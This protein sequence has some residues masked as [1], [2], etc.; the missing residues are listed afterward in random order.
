MRLHVRALP[1]NV[2]FASRT[3]LTGACA[4]VRGKALKQFE[5][6]TENIP[7]F[8]KRWSVCSGP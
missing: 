1:Q 5:Y 8:A 2:Q 7:P 3:R 4:S 6:T